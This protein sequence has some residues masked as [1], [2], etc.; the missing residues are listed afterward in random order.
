MPSRTGIVRACL[1]QQLP[2]FEACRLNAAMERTRIRFTQQPPPFGGY[3]PSRT[4]IMGLCFPQQS[5]TL[6]ERPKAPIGSPMAAGSQQFP[7][8]GGVPEGRGGA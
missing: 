8:F 5:P 1:S 3:M 2:S 6:K 7:S 4:G